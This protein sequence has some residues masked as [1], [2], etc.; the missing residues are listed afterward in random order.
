[1]P[2]LA[3]PHWIMSRNMRMMSVVKKATANAGELVVMPRILRTIICFMLLALASCSTL[4]DQQRSRNVAMAEGFFDNVFSVDPYTAQVLLHSEFSFA[5][6]SQL[7]ISN[8]NYDRDTFFSVWLSIVGS[9]APKGIVFK[10]VGTIAD[11]HGVA[12]IMTGDGEGINGEY[13]NAYVFIFKMQDGKIRSIEEYNSDL[14]TAT[15]LYTN[16]LVPSN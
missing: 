14:L 7:P 16:K 10:T 9:L 2:L 3:Y 15:R 5:Y 12:L 11:D 13:D 6:K 8:V 4:Q 1:M